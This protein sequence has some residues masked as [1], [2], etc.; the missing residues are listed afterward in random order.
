MTNMKME[1]NNKYCFFLKCSISI[2]IMHCNLFV[3]HHA[4][5]VLKDCIGMEKNR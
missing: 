1:E 3:L 2:I 5:F 4:L